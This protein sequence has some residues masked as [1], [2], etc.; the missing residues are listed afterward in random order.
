MPGDWRTWLI[1]A[2]TTISTL[3]IRVA[4]RMHQDAVQSQRERADDQRA[5]AEAAELRADISEDQ[6][7]IIL[8]GVLAASGSDEDAAM[9]AQA[10]AATRFRRRN[11][12][13]APR[14]VAAQDDSADPDHRGPDEGAR[15]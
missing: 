4:Y 8:G 6:K 1:F 2:L 15:G 7:M 12:S 11:G 10:T 9:V 5:R 14:S 3:L 13:R